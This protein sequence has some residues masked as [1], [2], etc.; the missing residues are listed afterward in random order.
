MGKKVLLKYTPQNFVSRSR[1]EEKLILS[2]QPQ[3]GSKSSNFVAW[4]YPKIIS[5]S[6]SPH[7]VMQCMFPILYM[8]SQLIYFY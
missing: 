7:W 6:L 8:H 2:L 5:L 1:E 3:D 4:I